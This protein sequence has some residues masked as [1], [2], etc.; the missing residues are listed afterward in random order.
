VV[1]VAEI[2]VDEGNEPDFLAHLFDAHL[3]PG[4]HS[5]EIDFLA[6]EADAPAGGHGSPEL[7]S[8]I[9]PEL[10]DIGLAAED[11]AALLFDQMRRQVRRQSGRVN[12]S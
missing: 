2:I 6:I 12:L 10:A 11:C 3:L 9:F 8:C 1:E 5:A 4:E 7:T